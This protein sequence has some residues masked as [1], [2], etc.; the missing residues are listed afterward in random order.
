MLK[1]AALGCGGFIG[2]HL[3]DRLLADPGYSVVGWDTSASKIAHHLSNPRLAFHLGDVYAFPDLDRCLADCDVVISLAAMCN[4]SQYTVQGLDVIESNFILPRTIADR[5]ARLGKW[6]IQFS[7]SE[8]YGQTLAHRAR[9]SAPRD[10]HVVLSEDSSP[11]LMGTVAEQRWSYA[12]AKQLLE[13][14][15]VALHRERGL[16]YTVIRPFNFLGTRM[17]YLPGHDGEGLP[18]V[19]ACFTSA[20]IDKQPMALVDGGH[21]KRT[22]LAI[23]EAVDALVLMMHSP[24]QAKNRVFNLGHPENEVTIR[25]LA[26]LMRQVAVEVSGEAEYADLPLID[27][28]AL[29]FYGEGYA[30]SDRRMPDIGK[31]RQCLGWEPK[32]RLPEILRPILAEAFRVYANKPTLQQFPDRH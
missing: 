13:R 22:F 10:E 26:E 7:T 25:E 27:V 32:R 15:I 21:A 24:E 31:A 5:C 14:Y 28:P 8:V 2:S 1:I 11:L 29:E 30:D 18:R 3:L 12:C 6:L 16:D 20:I 4:P 19:L 17:D 9:L 23:E